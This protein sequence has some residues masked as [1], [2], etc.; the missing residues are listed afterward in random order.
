MEIVPETDQLDVEAQLR[1]EDVAHVRIGDIAK[2]TLTAYAQ[3]R[4]PVVTGVVVNVSADR[5]VDQRTGQGYFSAQITVDSASLKDY[6]RVRLVPGMPVEVAV[7][8]GKRTA[9][10]YLIMPIQAVIRR[11][12][13]E[14]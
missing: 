9:L 12:M 13:R 4:L 5:L 7:E 8:T 10:D 6:P 14:N 3:R 11:G 1:P 2:V